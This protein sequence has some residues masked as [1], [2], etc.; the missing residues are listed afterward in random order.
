MENDFFRLL[1][2]VEIEG[3]KEKYKIFL[4]L[5]FDFEGKE[6]FFL[7]NKKKIVEKS[8]ESSFAPLYKSQVFQGVFVGGGEHGD[9]VEQEAQDQGER[10]CSGCQSSGV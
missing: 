3:K 10:W 7:G 1:F 6:F 8:L 9:R 2:K 4:F 5:N